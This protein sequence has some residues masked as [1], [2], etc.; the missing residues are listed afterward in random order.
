VIL[1]SKLTLNIVDA[2]NI[3][4]NKKNTNLLGAEFQFDRFYREFAIGAG[5]GT[6]FDFGF[7]V[8]RFDA[9]I[10][11]RDPSMSPSD[12][13]VLPHTTLKKINFNLGIGYPF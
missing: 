5:F 12:R 3:W 2:G 8:L 6:R 1:I 11:L 9:A 10:P 7:F 4:L 13:W